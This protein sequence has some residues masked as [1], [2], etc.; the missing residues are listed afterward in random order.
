MTKKSIA[1]KTAAVSHS[2]LAHA[3][4][5]TVTDPLPTE[6]AP[7]PPAESVGVKAKRGLRPQRS[8]VAIAAKMASELRGSDSYATLFG[9]GAPAASSVADALVTASNWSGSLQN[10][11][12]WYQYVKQQEGLAWEHAL[13]LTDPLRVPFEFNLTRDATVG[14][15]LPST[16]KFFAAKSESGKKAAATRKKN[17]AEKKAAAVET[18]TPPAAQTPATVAATTVTTSVPAAKLLN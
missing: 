2:I 18:S 11:E 6:K 9:S 10:A 16:A 14:E 3:A 17:Q 8:Q 12:T 4:G 1:T 13:G 5:V 15:T 7:S